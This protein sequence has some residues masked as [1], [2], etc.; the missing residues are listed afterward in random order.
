MGFNS[1]FKG[2]TKCKLFFILVSAVAMNDR[3][4]GKN[5]DMTAGWNTDKACFDSGL[6]RDT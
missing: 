5:G 6:R 3:K 1:G 4:I 2:L